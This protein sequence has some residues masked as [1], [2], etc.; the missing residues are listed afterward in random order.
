MPETGMA[1]FEVPEA[2][3]FCD[4][5]SLGGGVLAGS[6]AGAVFSAGRGLAAEGGVGV[7]DPWP[8]AVTVSVAGLAAPAIAI[9]IRIVCPSRTDRSGP[10]PFQSPS[11]LTSTL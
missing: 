8:G 2:A 1:S 9:G 3:V 6:A 5:R 11:A 10:R 4:P 7:G